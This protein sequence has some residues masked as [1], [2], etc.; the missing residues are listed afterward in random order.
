[1]ITKTIKYSCVFFIAIC[2]SCK[3]NPKEQ[4]QINVEDA[5]DATANDSIENSAEKSKA[6]D[7]YQITFKEAI[8]DD[9]TKSL[10]HVESTNFDDFIDPDDYKEIDTK[11]FK[12]ESIYPNFHKEGHNYRAI[13]K[14]LLPLHEDFYSVVLTVLKGENEMETVLVNYNKDGYVIDQ[15]VVSYDEI[16]EGWTKRISRI[17]EHKLTT[18]YITWFDDK[19]IEQTEYTINENGTIT[20][21]RSEYLHKSIADYDLINSVLEK[22]DLKWVQLKTDLITTKTFTENPKESVIIL[23]K[24]K[25]EGEGYIELNVDVVVA[26]NDLE[27]NNLKYIKSEEPMVITSD[28]IQLRGIIIEDT[29]YPIA[30]HTKA[31]GIKT[32]FV[33]SSRVNPYE[34]KALFLYIKLNDKLK[35][36]LTNYEVMSNG[37][38]WVNECEGEE[39]TNKKTLEIIE[40]KTNDYFDIKVRS[41]ITITTS[42]ENENGDCT[43][44]EATGNETHILKYN[45]NTYKSA[46]AVSDDDVS[47]YQL[48]VFTKKQAIAYYGEPQLKEQFVL[49]DAQGE[50]RIGLLDKFTK[51][52]RQAEIIKIDEFTWE[53]NPNTWVTVWYEKDKPNSRPVDIL[54]W[55]KGSEF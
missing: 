4:F 12:L 51:K 24:V 34:S 48:M 29:L 15:C 50:F 19:E 54:Q 35:N 23:P 7:I 52:Q 31:Y 25:D 36:I 18:N 5:V 40:T 1:M 28:A 32:H 8:E 2:C 46:I 21:E 16:A 42:Q 53:Q 14:Y 3:Q 22:L 10:P 27:N 20:K 43:T 38:E 33:G 17:S 44:T 30:E 55:D 9:V 45:G 41:D 6:N 39:V 13:R 49:D 37:G 11:I 26:D 47:V